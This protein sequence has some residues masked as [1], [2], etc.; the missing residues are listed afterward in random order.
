[1]PMLTTNSVVYVFLLL[2]LSACGDYD[3][4]K[5]R[6][7]LR[8]VDPFA[9]SVTFAEVKEQVFTRNCVACHPGYANYDSVV[10]DLPKILNQIEQDRMP[11][12]RS[13]LT[14]S[15]KDVLFN[16]SL[17][18]APLGEKPQETSTSSELKPSWNS[19][20][21]KVFHAKCVTCHNPEGQ[22]PWVDL[23]T[24]NAIFQQRTLLLNFDDPEQSLL[25]EV[26]SDPDEPM[27]PKESPFQRLSPEEIEALKEWIRLGLPN[28]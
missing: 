8:S 9:E 12:G 15:Q 26:V 19:L 2:I 28:E 11:K 10:K 4:V 23:R 17:A 3:K 1:M 27:P 24:R 14:S 18:G 22:V 21:Q 5:E 6:P 20:A 13:P 16:W 25:V 7:L